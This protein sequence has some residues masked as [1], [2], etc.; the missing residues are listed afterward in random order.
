MSIDFL[1][2]DF[3]TIINNSFFGICDDDDTIDKTPAY[4]DVE[5]EDNWITK[6]TNSNPPIEIVFTAIDHGLI[7]NS[8]EIDNPKRCDG[9]LQ[10]GDVIIF[11]ELKN[12]LKKPAQILQ[13]ENTIKLFCDN[14]DVNQ[15][16]K[17][18]AF[19]SNKKKTVFLSQDTKDKFK[20]ENKGF[21]LYFSTEINI[22]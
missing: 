8:R 5:N 12:K 22:K 10:Y 17:R 2:N 18:E 7:K 4:V 19:L 15:F 1:K 11:V 14:H 9:M 20:D 6:V 3:Q 13:L 21:R 16:N